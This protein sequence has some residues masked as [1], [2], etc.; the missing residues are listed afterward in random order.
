MKNDDNKIYYNF[1]NLS[2]IENILKYN[3]IHIKKYEE[4]NLEEYFS[5][6]NNEEYSKYIKNSIKIVDLMLYND[7][8]MTNFLKILVEKNTESIKQKIKMKMNLIQCELF[9][10]K[11]NKEEFESKNYLFN[12][13]KDKFIFDLNS[14]IIIKRVIEFYI[15]D[16]DEDKDKINEKDLDK[17]VIMYGISFWNEEK[18]NLLYSSDNEKNIAIGI[19]LRQKKIEFYKETYNYCI[20]LNS[21]KNFG[22]QRDLLILRISKYYNNKELYFFLIETF[23]IKKLIDIIR[24]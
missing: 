9:D 12:L 22:D 6:G 5:L 18:Y 16:E 10:N 7:G 23:Q 1:F 14:N 24:N 17:N 2:E 20:E 4:L 21:E 13:I 19:I 15:E 3:L 11:E 8:S